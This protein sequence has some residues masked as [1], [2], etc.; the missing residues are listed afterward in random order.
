MNQ[1]ETRE[2]KLSSFLYIYI[3][4]IVFFFCLLI[5]FEKSATFIRLY[6]IGA[7]RIRQRLVSNT[8][9]RCQHIVH[10][11]R[12]INARDAIF[13]PCGCT[14]ISNDDDD[15]G[16]YR[17]LGTNRYAKRQNCTG[18]ERT[19]FRVTGHW[20]HTLR[21]FYNA[22][23]NRIARRTLYAAPGSTGYYRYCYCQTLRH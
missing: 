4:L 3:F 15:D 9:T 23:T 6:K 8:L 21:P 1:L 2:E 14:T 20:E 13:V 10:P 7:P 22:A 5:S 11:W 17:R 18:I 16:A 19:Q 12:A